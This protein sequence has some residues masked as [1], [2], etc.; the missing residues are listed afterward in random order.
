M[1]SEQNHDDDRTVAADVHDQALPHANK[2]K[3]WAGP[4]NVATIIKRELLPVVCR[5]DEIR[6]CA[7]ARM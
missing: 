1:E 3:S 5:E 7:R 2:T 6:D 4:G